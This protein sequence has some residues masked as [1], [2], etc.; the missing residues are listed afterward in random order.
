MAQWSLTCWACLYV[1]LVSFNS[2][3][4][5]WL[6]NVK[7]SPDSQTLR[8]WS[9]GEL[10]YRLG[11]LLECIRWTS[12]WT[13]VTFM[14]HLTGLKSDFT[15][16][17]AVCNA[18]FRSTLVLCE[19]TLPLHSMTV[20]SP[21]VWVLMLRALVHLAK[22]CNQAQPLPQHL[23]RCCVGQS[24]KHSAYFIL[25]NWWSWQWQIQS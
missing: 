5:S 25:F 11:R 8:P 17:S 2:N 6:S 23:P 16:N 19:K 14:L 15:S 21:A 7:T 1:H 3:L 24:N 22:K 9:P 13:I 4:P 10:S 12:I 18:S 20:A